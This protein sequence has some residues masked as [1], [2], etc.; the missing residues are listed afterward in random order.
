MAQAGIPTS[1]IFMRPGTNASIGTGA[2][3]NWTRETALDGKYPYVTTGLADDA[4]TTGG[5]LT[6]THT[7][8][9]AAHN[10]SAGAG[11][12]TNYIS[13]AT[14][15]T[16]AATVTHT[17]ASTSSNTS[18]ENSGTADNNPLHISV[19]FI[20]PTSEQTSIPVG[21]W[22][23]TS[24]SVPTNWFLSTSGNGSYICGASGGANANTVQTGTGSHT[25]TASHGH[26]AKNSASASARGTRNYG[27]GNLCAGGTHVHSVS[28]DAVDPGMSSS[29]SDSPTYRKFGIIQQTSSGTALPT[30][31]MAFY[32]GTVANKPNGWG[33]Y[34]PDIT[35]FDFIQ[36][37]NTTGE[38]LQTGGNISLTHNHTGVSHYHTATVGEPSTGS[39]PDPDVSEFSTYWHTHVWTIS[40]ATDTINNGIARGIYPPYTKVFLA[41]YTGGDFAPTP[42]STTV[43]SS[44]VLSSTT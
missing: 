15:L 16:A 7:V 18:T 4:G 25:H 43:Y 28:L 24:G 3:A 13:P 11:N 31:V 14:A 21:A 37:T 35:G 22:A 1:I 23:L 26:S 27:A 42:P 38:I 39:S 29:S 36:G 8:S 10:F 20:K 32:I 44:L 2:L 6:H 9:T 17:H 33:I 30:G 5:S 19:I 40:N 41:Y 34:N 12:G